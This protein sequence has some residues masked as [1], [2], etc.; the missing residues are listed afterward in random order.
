MESGRTAGEGREGRGLVAGVRAAFRG[1]PKAAPKPRC[2]GPDLDEAHCHTPSPPS[3]SAARSQRSPRSPILGWR[4]LKH[5]ESHKGKECARIEETRISDKS[6][7]CSRSQALRLSHHSTANYTNY[8]LSSGLGL[9]GSS[10]QTNGCF[11]RNIENHVRPR[12]MSPSW[13]VSKGIMSKKLEENDNSDSCRQE[14]LIE[15]CVNGGA[16][17]KA[18]EGSD[19]A[20]VTP[21]SDMCGDHQGTVVSHVR[22]WADVEGEGEHDGKLCISEKNDG[23]LIETLLTD[24]AFQDNRRL[25]E[26]R[27]TQEREP[28]LRSALAY[29]LRV[30]QCPRNEVVVLALGVDQYVE[31]V[32][33][34]LDQAGTG[35]VGVEDFHAL[36]RVL[37]LE[38]EGVKNEEQKC[39]CLGSTLTL[40][41]SLNDSAASDTVSEAPCAAHLSFREFRE[42]LCEVFIRNADAHSLLSLGA[43]RPANAPLV[44]SVV[45]VQRRYEVLEAIS[46]K[47]AEVTARLKC[48][49]ESLKD[50]GSE[51][52]CGKC[53]QMIH[54]DRNSNISPRP[55][56]VEVSFLQRQ[57]LLQQ[58]ELQ[59][60]REVIDDL[61]VALQSSDAENLALQVQALKLA[62]WRQGASLQDLSLTDEEDT[63]DNLL[64]QLAELG[65]QS[66]LGAPPAPPKDE[67]QEMKEKPPPSQDT[68]RSTA[69][70][71]DLPGTTFPSGDASLE[72]ELQA[73]YEALQTAREEQEATQ[74]DLQQTVSQLQ[75]REAELRKV[76]GSLETAQSALG[77]AH[78]E[79]L[80]LVTEVAEARTSLQDSHS[81]LAQALN[82]LQQAKDIIMQKEK[83]L[84]ET[85]L[86]L[87]QL[88]DSN[89]KNPHHHTL[90]CLQSSRH[91]PPGLGQHS[92]SPVRE[93][94][95]ARV[96]T[97]RE[98]VAGSLGQVRAGEHALVALAA[99]T[100]RTR[101]EDA[102]RADS[103]LYSEDS[104]RDEDTCQDRSSEHASAS[105]ED[106]WSLRGSDSSPKSQSDPAAPATLP[107][108]WITTESN[109]CNNSSNSSDDGYKTEAGEPSHASP[110]FTDPTLTSNCTSTEIIE[111][112]ERELEWLQHTLEEA[113]KECEEESS[114]QAKE[115]PVVEEPKPPGELRVEES[116][117]ER[118]SHLEEQLKQLLEALMSVADMNLSRR[119][120]G[121]LVLEA[122]QDASGHAASTMRPGAEDEVPPISLLT[123]LLASL[124][125]HAPAKQ[126]EETTEWL[127]H[128]A[129]RGLA[130]PAEA[131]ERVEATMG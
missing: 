81:R 99:H 4:K 113:E 78:A 94:V 72:D 26:A 122:V 3:A 63:I 128:S 7:Q 89:G 70:K 112:L 115:K 92:P 32:F 131:R 39:R 14:K 65:P 9:V 30:P 125:H 80:N 21:G 5:K 95:V 18:P 91:A 103:G 76:E 27:R 36:C 23:D 46:R 68:E 105:E 59:C 41:G 106:L 110:F 33:R 74:A 97:A 126:Q 118:L 31:E 83:Q 62:R 15:R 86:R 2:D 38:D 85:Q 16:V 84:E 124:P 111:G 88:R 130:H 24:D 11:S 109:S 43:R 66:M 79:N 25:E 1:K 8:T 64:R 12:E 22:K 55:R 93:R 19:S 42:R 69:S 47:L 35:K 120:L 107:P 37:G 116:D 121:R 71:R 50:E 114:Q 90:P 28:W 101:L 56:H 57:V 44:S 82:E 77:Q 49:E 51:P 29:S 75:Q 127:F 13:Q 53:Q 20:K 34:F 40:L 98:L 87:D 102:R 119:T 104:E 108:P 10:E 17:C 54:V 48:E 45:S 100:A 73:T 52:V 123:R 67:P 96:G 58:Q 117:R 129:L 6:G 61:R 60:L